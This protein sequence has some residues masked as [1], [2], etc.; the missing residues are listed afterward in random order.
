MATSRVRP[1]RAGLCAAIAVGAGFLASASPVAAAGGHSTVAS[2]PAC[3]S[4]SVIGSLV[5][6]LDGT[7][8][9]GGGG[10]TVDQQRDEAILAGVG[11]LGVGGAMLIQRRRQQR[12][13]SS[14]LGPRARQG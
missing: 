5:N 8:G 11:I 14:R 9:C 1:R 7:T 6:P 3:S 4:S 2:A 13:R 10:A 12:R